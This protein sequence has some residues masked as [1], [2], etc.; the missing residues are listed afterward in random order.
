MATRNFWPQLPSFKGK[1]YDVWVIKME[2]MLKLHDVWD[3]VKFGF[4]EPHNDAEEKALSN[5]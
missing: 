2:T 4:T 1:Y 3:H 5:A